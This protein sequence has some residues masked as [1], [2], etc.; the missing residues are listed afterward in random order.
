MLA[1]SFRLST[2]DFGPSGCA[3]FTLNSRLVPVSRLFA[4]VSRLEYALTKKRRRNSFRIHSYKFIGLK[5]PWND[6]VTKNTGWGGVPLFLHWLPEA[7][8]PPLPSW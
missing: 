1:S 6:I 3:L 8:R 2:F 5:V 4:R 7:L